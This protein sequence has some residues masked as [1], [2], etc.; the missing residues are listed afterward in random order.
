M[1]KLMQILSVAVFL[2]LI[3]SFSPVQ[4]VGVSSLQ[5]AGVDTGMDSELAQDVSHLLPLRGMSYTPHPSDQLNVLDGEGETKGK[6]KWNYFDSD[7]TN[8]SFPGLWGTAVADARGDLQKMRDLG[9]NFLHPYDWSVPGSPYG[10]PPE[11]GNG[12]NDYRRNHIPFL[13]ECDKQGIKCM[14]PIS[15]YF[16][17]RVKRGETDTFLPKDQIQA[18]V[19]EIFRG[20]TKP[21]PAAAMWA[22]GNEFI[23]QVTLR[24]EPN[25]VLRVEWPETIAEARRNAEVIA[26]IAQWIIEKEEALGVTND[27][28][29][30][31]NDQLPIT[32]TVNFGELPREG[33]TANDGT[34]VGQNPPAIWQ[35]QL[36]KEA[37]QANAF[38]K[39]RKV[40]EERFI[41]SVQ[42]FNGGP[43]LKNWIVNTFP[44]RFGSVPFF[45]SELGANILSGGGTEEQQAVW[46]A[47]QLAGAGEPNG[48]FMGSCVFQW[49]NQTARKTGA[50]EPFFGIHRYAGAFKEATIPDIPPG[51]IP[52]G[53]Y[54]IDGL[55]EKPS[56]NS[57]RDAWN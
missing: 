3:L 16:V 43:F 21:H 20:G 18:I 41:A 23:T 9:V 38:L 31:D 5:G 44:E 34:G 33:F 37:F 42:T 35:I 47:G 39:A 1:K 22:I 10:P 32:A 54:L 8:E 56:Y 28:H 45:I 19:A 14:I 24:D 12:P 13:D 29:Q 25:A 55:H 26:T 36:L 57:V 52:G 30:M 53:T 7:F 15:N 11:P 4:P 40:W 17:G 50:A 6:P 49:L 2:M 27:N 46:V 51:Y 48:N